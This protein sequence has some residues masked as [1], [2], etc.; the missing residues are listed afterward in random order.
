MGDE[1]VERPEGAELRAE[2]RKLLEQRIDAL[3]EQF[4]T[5]F[6]LRDIEE[7][8][9]DEVAACLDVPSETVR[10]RAFRARALLRESL[11]RDIDRETVKCVRLRRTTLRSHRLRGARALARPIESDPKSAAC[12]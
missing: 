1:A 12:A 6:I 5:A 4:R 2:L 9:V 10:S 11:S 8:S 3:P 7:L